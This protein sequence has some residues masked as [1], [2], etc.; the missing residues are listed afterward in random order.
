MKSGWQKKRLGEVATVTAGNPAPQDPTHFKDG[1]HPFF[2][3]ADAGRVR[4]GEIREATDYLNKNGTKG[5]RL[6]PKGTILFPKSGASTFLNHRVLLDVEGYVSSHLATIV[7]DQ[8]KVNER[9]LLYFLSTVYAQ[10]LVQDQAYPSLNL[11]TI[12]G[13]EVRFPLLHEQQRIVTILN[14][15]FEGIAT[16]KANAEKNLQNVQGIFDSH[17]ESIFGQ[18]NDGWIK[19]PLGDVCEYIN[20]KAHEQFITEDGQYIVINSKFISTEGRIFKKSNQVL[21]PLLPGDIAMVLSDV[22]N[23]RA[24]AKCFHVEEANTYTLNQRICLIRSKHFHSKFLVGVQL[25]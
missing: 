4:F 19:R 21:L 13:I 10:D 16:T 23:G 8:S 7:A 9:Y 11:P 6:Y 12:A 22:P 5:L 24:L 1:I 17:L 15:A 14:E 3:T 20:G 2:R 25:L 18:C